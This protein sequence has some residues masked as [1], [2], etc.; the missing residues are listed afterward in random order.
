MNNISK[1]HTVPPLIVEFIGLP[2]AG[3][4]TVSRRV[5]SEL[6]SAGH[7]CLTRDVWGELRKAHRRSHPSV[8]L[9]D[10]YQ[11]FVFCVR[12]MHVAFHALSYALQVTPLNMRSL[13]HGVTFLRKLYKLYFIRRTVREAARGGYDIILFDQGLMQYIWWIAVPRSPLPDISLIRLLKSVS[14]EMPQVFVLFDVDVPTAIE[15]ITNRSTMGSYFDRFDRI[16]SDTPESLL[17][18]YKWYVENV[19]NCAAQL[20]GACR[21]LR[22][23]GNDDVGEIASSIVRFIDEIWQSRVHRTSEL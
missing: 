1:T 3:K 10:V 13:R 11:F 5:V 18:R 12:H 23:N 7:K 6:D 20:N 16:S 14:D 9:K 19:A 8:S 2:G 17:G 4:T 22:V 21:L 15:R